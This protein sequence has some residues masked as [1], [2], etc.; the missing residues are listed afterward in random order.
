MS[1]EQGRGE[2]LDSRSDIYSLGVVLY[3][4]ATG[5][6]PYRADTPLAV[7]IKHMQDPL[8]PPR[9]INP[10]L[11]LAVEQVILKALAKRRE[12][13]YQ[14][15]GEIAQAI[16]VA[17]PEAT[18]LADQT[19]I[20]NAFQV[21]YKMPTK[22]SVL[23]TKKLKTGLPKRIL[24]L[25]G[26][27]LIAISI[28][29]VVMGSRL[30]IKNSATGTPT[31]AVKQAVDS[32]ITAAVPLSTAVVSLLP[33]TILFQDNFDDGKSDRWNGN[34][35][36][37]EVVQDENGNYVY[38][39]NATD[40]WAYAMPKAALFTWRNYSIE[41]RWKVVKISNQLD[42]N[43]A[44]GQVTFRN[45][46]GKPNG[47]SFYGV[48][49]DT[50]NKFVSL[51]RQG[52]NPDCEWAVLVDKKYEFESGQWYDL[53]IETIGTTHKVYVNGNLF[54]QANDE[55]VTQGAFEIDAAPGAIVQFDDVK[56]WALS[57]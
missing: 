30:G 23:R 27:A 8:P 41:L 12:G 53:R 54:L 17:I 37:W 44:D 18:T 43:I 42:D 35:G 38:Q 45:Q 24:A 10:S 28:V 13:R 3:E 57:E 22:A 6:V 4:M 39:G 52:F 32:G 34:G 20:A 1:P 15:A 7:I 50:V 11:P 31:A 26:L 25:G 14:T 29:A 9:S 2:T 19:E 21:E 36:I 16:Q 48:F 51:A 49:F 33:G 56:V 5:R 46:Y 55:S 40:G 47:C